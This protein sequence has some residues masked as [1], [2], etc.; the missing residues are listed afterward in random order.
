MVNRSGKYPHVMKV[1]IIIPVYNVSAYIERCLQS[2]INQT[3]RGAMECIIVDDCSPDDSIEK[4][5][6]MLAR[7]KGTIEFRFMRH[8]KNKG[9]S[10]ARNSGTNVATGDYIFYLDSD[11]EITPHCIVTMTDEVRRHPSVEL[12]QGYTMSVPDNE[13]YHT[14]R[15]KTTDFVS[16][17][18]WI[19][20]E[21]YNI[22][23]KFPCNAWNKL[24]KKSFLINNDLFFKEGIIH[25]DEQWSFFVARRLNQLAITMCPTYIHYRTE[26]SIMTSSS[27]YGER[28]NKSWSLIL[29]DFLNNIDS[30]T[31]NLQIFL[32]IDQF[33]KR[34][35]YSEK[36]Y[37]RHFPKIARTLVKHNRYYATLLFTVAFLLYNKRGGNR[38]YRMLKSELKKA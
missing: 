14:E 3:Y 15:Y 36:E 37:I 19:R 38:C 29:N 30:S 25:E 21:F 26:G 23:N 2:V 22:D 20:K 7:Y 16:D 32:C 1:S 24:I 12:V 31:Y 27:L 18:T 4:C 8:Q 10:G 35:H 28:N 33:L 9:L 34:Y 17:N 13:Y 5:K 6:R 11:D